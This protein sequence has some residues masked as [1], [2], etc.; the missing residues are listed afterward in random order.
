MWWKSLEV[1]QQLSVAVIVSIL[2][3]VGVV[4]ADQPVVTIDQKGYLMCED[5]EENCALCVPDEI[6][7]P[8]PKGIDMICFPVS[9]KEVLKHALDYYHANTG[10]TL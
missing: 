2:L 10:V 7:V 3:I 6:Q 1:W 5:G 9:T 4:K 8:N